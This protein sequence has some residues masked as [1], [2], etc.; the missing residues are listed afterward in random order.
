MATLA[1][2]TPKIWPRDLPSDAMNDAEQ[3]S[4]ALVDRIHRALEAAGDLPGV[5]VSLRTAVGRTVSVVED[6][7]RQIPDTS[8]ERSAPTELSG[9]QH[10][11]FSFGLDDGEQI[12]I[13]SAREG[14]AAAR[15]VGAVLQAFF[16]AL[17]AEKREELLLQEL[18]ANWESMEVLYEISTDALR[19]GHIKDAMQ[20]LIQ[21]LASLKD[22]LH[23]ALFVKREGLF[24]P[25]ASTGAE[26]S[27]LAPE[28]LGEIESAM[29]E[30]R[31][32][33]AN[34]LGELP[35]SRAL[36]ERVGWRNAASLAAAPFSREGCVG[37]VA[38]WSEDPGCH[39]DQSFARVLEAIAYQV[40]VMM[41]SDRL[42]RKVRESQLLAQE[43]E[44][45]SSIQQTLL[46][47]NAPKD[48]HRFEIAS[49]SLPSQRIDGD[50]H[51]FFQLPDGSIDVLIG[52]VM[53]KGV[54]AALL[55]AA[56][57]SQ[58][59][60][61]TANLALQSNPT[62]PRPAEIVA[63]A[64][65]RLSE[66]LISLERFVTLCYARFDA[67]SR[68][69]SLVDCGHTSVIVDGKSQTD[70]EL[71]TGGDLPLGVVPDFS[72]EERSVAF[73]P[74][75]TY[76]LYSDGVT[77]NRAPNGEMFGVE[78]LSECVRNW[79]SLGPAKLVA[80]IRSEAVR[81]RG[82]EKFA[83]DFTCIAVRI[84]A[85]PTPAKPIA[86]GSAVFPRENDQL[87]R[88]R[89]WLRG[90]VELGGA[91][92]S[93]DE[94]ARL[95]LCCTEIFVNCV[96]HAG[97]EQAGGQRKDDGEETPVGVEI[98]IF[99]QQT[100][101]EVR[102]R[103]REFDPLAVP[104]PAFDGSRD[105]GFGIY[106][107]LRSADN[108]RFARDADGTNIITLTFLRSEADRSL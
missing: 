77:E 36:D 28:Q 86:R 85:D 52:D 41:A 97:Y 50:F 59:L 55:G 88:L 96:V 37:F 100:T 89:S 90:Q 73:T 27:S 10:G 19:S 99:P 22:G 102:H 87:A 82:S 75:Q 7:R 20:R 65:S 80:Q 57:K 61:A 72:C 11:V 60:R 13:R 25:L 3:S 8:I 21:R 46:L 26:L 68:T 104:P 33:L 79:S 56:T 31:V 18:G 106:I 2:T 78:R 94:L 98:A 43:V 23:S 53:G 70:C 74:G 38:V 32:A 1:G 67:V 15:L 95:E 45:A 44:I 103:G 107:V 47:A 63:R 76:L 64:A 101:V 35:Q 16:R 58:F 48:A 5:S 6:G 40:A 29:L 108:A 24:V 83:D 66:R 17:A 49:C 34:R 93:E 42:N 84:Q 12:E 4:A 30:M 71:L 9:A 14:A 92:L 69:L 54:A 91:P 62:A 81:F 51:D 39:F 105:G